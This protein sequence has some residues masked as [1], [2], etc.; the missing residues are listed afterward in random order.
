[1]QNSFEHKGHKGFS[2]AV[3]VSFVVFI[4]ACAQSPDCLR[5]DVFCAALVTNT[6]GVEDHGVNQDVWA[7]LEEAKTTGLADHA[8]YIESVDARDYQ[9][10]I[11]YFAD[12]GYDLIVTTGAG[13]H[14][15]TLRAADLHPDSVFVGIN[16]TH[17]EPRPNLTAVTFPEDQMG[18]LAGVLAGR[19][20]K[21]GV[22]GGVCETSGIG[23]MWRY[24]EGFRAGAEYAGGVHRILV[25]YRDDGDSE[26]LFVDEAWGYDTAKNLIFRGA[27]VIFAAGGATGQG[28]LR[29]AAEAGVPAI[30]VEQDQAA[31]LGESGK[32]VV[33]SILGRA[34]FEVREV[35]RLLSEGRIPQ[36]RSGQIGFTPLPQQFPESLTTEM[37]AVLLRLWFGEIQTN[38][39]FE[40]P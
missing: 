2:L 4:S 21:T 3:F 35:M 40:K 39:P 36:E 19:L 1:M 26:R 33:T 15:E 6:L 12:R 13:M 28:A 25:S 30:G 31:A 9:K 37:D 27:D 14:D 20:T 8:A 16:Q 24:C 11:A 7:G 32:G 23:A 22:V 29:A 17:R 18:F 34:G 10:N 5:E 38:V